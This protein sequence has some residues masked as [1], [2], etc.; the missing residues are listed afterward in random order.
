MAT[1]ILLGLQKSIQEMC[2]IRQNKFKSFDSDGRLEM[3]DGK[4]HLLSDGET[5]LLSD[6]IC[7]DGKHFC[8]IKVKWKFSDGL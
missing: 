4:Q 7:T 1:R 6:G 3:S 2:L 5:K 8:L